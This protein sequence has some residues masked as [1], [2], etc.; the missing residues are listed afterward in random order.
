MAALLLASPEEESRHFADAGGWSIFDEKGTCSA[1]SLFER[2]T[3]VR[4]EHDFGEDSVFLVVSDPAWES[5]SRGTEYKAKIIFSNG[6]EWENATGVGLRNEPTAS[7]QI[8][9]LRFHLDGDE[10][11]EA[12]AKSGA[13]GIFMGDTRLGVFDLTGTRAAVGALRRC[14]IESHKRYPPDPFR[15]FRTAT[16]AA[17]GNIAVSAGARANLASYVTDSDYPASAVERGEQ[18]TV[19]FTLAIGADGRVTG[20]TVTGSSGSA[21]LDSTTCRIMRSRARFTP[22]RDSNGNP[23]ADS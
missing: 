11:L 15:K 9:G 13:M 5:V 23:T 8:R 14:A 7:S 19:R 1:A 12:F 10:F 16:S 22:A 21:V 17:G 4:V 3:L 2:D 18:G 20:C 6:D